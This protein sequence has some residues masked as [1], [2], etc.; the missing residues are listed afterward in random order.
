MGKHS[1]N[2]KSQAG[3]DQSISSRMVI[4]RKTTPGLFSLIHRLIGLSKK[5]LMV[6]S[7]VRRY[8]N[9]HTAGDGNSVTLDSEE[10]PDGP[11]QLGRQYSN[12]YPSVAA[13]NTV[14]GLFLSSDNLIWV[15]LVF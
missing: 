8:R 2:P 3:L 14:P 10:L 7:M 11:H 1:H 6:P 12:K 15:K 13:E 4:K 9:T 5:R